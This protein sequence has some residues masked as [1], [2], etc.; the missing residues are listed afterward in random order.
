M[1]SSVCFCCVFCI[2]SSY[3]RHG[4]LKSMIHQHLW[5]LLVITST[6]TADVHSLCAQAG[7]D[8]IDFVLK[9][10]STTP[11]HLAFA[12][13]CV[14]EKGL[15]WNKTSK[16]MKRAQ[17]I[18]QTLSCTCELLSVYY[19]ILGSW[20]MERFLIKSPQLLMSSN[21]GFFQRVFKT[22]LA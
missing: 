11:P 7:I 1:W 12:C 13:P 19:A 6:S 20:G 4:F 8:G 2:F 21:L 9:E 10:L 3:S 16:G 17:D 14:K 15:R 22:N 18:F 5:N